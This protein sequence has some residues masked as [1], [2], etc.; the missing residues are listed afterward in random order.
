MCQRELQIKMDFKIS[1]SFEV[2]ARGTVVVIDEFSDSQ[3]GTPIQV[4]LSYKNKILYSGTAFKEYMLKGARK[5]EVEAFV[6][7][8]FIECPIPKGAV[9][10]LFLDVT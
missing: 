4:E 10:R 6:L 3:V 5:V 7:D 9:L 1:E 2:F 8:A